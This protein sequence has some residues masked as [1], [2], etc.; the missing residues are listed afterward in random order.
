MLDYGTGHTMRVNESKNRP[1]HI[2]RVPKGAKSLTNPL[3][4]YDIITS[5]APLVSYKNGPDTVRSLEPFVI[6]VRVDGKTR[7]IYSKV[8]P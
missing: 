8:E 7:D 6:R 3:R 1:P 4:R 5:H 2:A